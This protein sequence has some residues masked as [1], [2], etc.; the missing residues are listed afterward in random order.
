MSRWD[1]EADRWLRDALEDL[2]VA[3]DLLKLSHYA[4]SCFHSQQAAEKALKALPI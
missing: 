3:E 4:A 2:Q 1:I